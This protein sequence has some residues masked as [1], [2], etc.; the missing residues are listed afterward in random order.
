V[1]VVPDGESDVDAITR[2]QWRL[3]QT[4]GHVPAQGVKGNSG[5]EVRFLISSLC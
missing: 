5:A 3:L 4:L 1:I 2:Q